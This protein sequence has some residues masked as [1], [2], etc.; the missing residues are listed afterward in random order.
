MGFL[1]SL[2]DATFGASG[3][4]AAMVM[5]GTTPDWWAVGFYFFVGVGLTAYVRYST[6]RAPAR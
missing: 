3:V 1:K 6:H 2:A 4:L 5:R